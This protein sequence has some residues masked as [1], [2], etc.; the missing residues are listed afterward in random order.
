MTASPKANWLISDEVFVEPATTG[1]FLPNGRKR[2]REWE[3]GRREEIH[4]EILGAESSQ[5]VAEKEDISFGKNNPLGNI[6]GSSDVFSTRFKNEL[7][8][9]EQEKQRAVNDLLKTTEV[10]PPK[11]S[12]IDL[13]DDEEE[14][15][16]TKPTD[17]TRNSMG[18]Q[19]RK[20]GLF[21]NNRAPTIDRDQLMVP[22]NASGIV[23]VMGRRI[24]VDRLINRNAS[25]YSMLR[26]WIKDDPDETMSPIATPSV[27]RKTLEDYRKQ[28]PIKEKAIDP[29]E[30]SEEDHSKDS[31][32]LK[33]SK[34][35]SNA[36]TKNKT[37]LFKQYQFDKKTRIAMR[38]K[39]IAAA[40]ANLRRR[41]INL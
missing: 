37:K 10:F 3:K 35:S 13:L 14:E 21:Q 38:K 32:G 39:R 31:K 2:Y 1:E 33:I 11:Y 34:A 22:P 29:T 4:R 24:H 6:L 41:G 17:I 9:I 30:N 12:V 5:R 7:K 23:S 40:R 18:S 15:E 19:R 16:D 20:S 8:R 28:R 25:L 27:R 36:K 26:S